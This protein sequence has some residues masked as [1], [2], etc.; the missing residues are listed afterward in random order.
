MHIQFKSSKFKSS[1]T[2]I[3]L[4]EVKESVKN[5]AFM[6]RG[7]HHPQLLGGLQPPEDEISSSVLYFFSEYLIYSGAI[8]SVKRHIKTYCRNARKEISFC[9][10]FRARRLCSK[11]A[12]FGKCRRFSSQNRGFCELF[13]YI[14]ARGRRLLSFLFLNPSP[15]YTQKKENLRTCV[16]RSLFSHVTS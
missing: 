11:M 2:S 13:I 4:T 6:P 1:K 14:K 7:R 9:I 15:A 5:R 10:C 16:H 12:I 8:F 3:L